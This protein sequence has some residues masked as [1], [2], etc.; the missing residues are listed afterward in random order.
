M[1]YYTHHYH[2]NVNN[3]VTTFIHSFIDVIKIL[4][5][6]SLDVDLNGAQ[7]GLDKVNI[8]DTPAS[9]IPVNSPIM[10]EVNKLI[11]FFKISQLSI[12]GF[13]LRLLG[14][15]RNR[16]RSVSVVPDL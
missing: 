14:P 5:E 4:Q 8:N 2:I 9:Y 12:Q 13:I 1:Y 16:L 10:E 6:V 15:S 3:I 11:Y 7:E